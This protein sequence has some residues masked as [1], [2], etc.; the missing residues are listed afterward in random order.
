MTSDEIKSL[1]DDA[2]CVNNCVPAGFQL[3]LLI[4]LI[5]DGVQSGGFAGGGGSGE[6]QSANYGGAQP[7]WTPASGTGIAF[8]ISDGAQWNYWS[9]GWH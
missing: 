6:M 3:A 5:W 4:A 1:L 8:D 7:N 2:R 9:G